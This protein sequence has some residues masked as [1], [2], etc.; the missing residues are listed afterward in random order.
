MAISAK[1]EADFTQFAAAVRTMEGHLAGFERTTT[2]TGTE[3]ST[4]TSTAKASSNTF[5]QLSQG[6]G[7]VDRTLGLL[8]IHIGPEIHALREMGE[9]AAAAQGGLSALA[10]GL[11]AVGAAFA[12]YQL[13]EHWD[14]IQ[15]S[16]RSALRTTDGWIATLVGEA[17]PA[18]EAAAAKLDLL[19]RASRYANT[20]ITDYGEA[21][22]IVVKHEEDLA[23][24]AKAAQDALEHQ[25]A[26][27]R[28]A[29]LEEFD[30][31]VEKSN[32]RVREERKKATDDA[33]AEA[34]RLAV[35]SDS[36]TGGDA[37]KKAQDYITVMSKMPSVAAMN[38][39][40]QREVE[41]AL[42]A[43]QEAMARQGRT[44]TELFGQITRWRQ[45]LLDL[46]PTE[47]E[48][49]IAMQAEA[50]AAA[51]LKTMEDAYT[52][53]GGTDLEG[54]KKGVSTGIGGE[55]SGP[56]GLAPF[57]GL[58]PSVFSAGGVNAPGASNVTVNMSGML[59]S[60]NPAAKEEL[61]GFVN[62]LVAEGLKR[63]RKVS[64]F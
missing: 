10:L 63:S 3:L 36:L 26:A 53:S 30:Q 29:F 24:S 20:T 13:Y 22:K 46:I 2:K 35:I 37:L 55:P 7:A 44:A 58:K 48:H 56:G 19:A 59:V 18:A 57:V 61:R 16:T 34:K 8:G 14:K 12:A 1:F 50:A 27:M 33:E 51:A 25:R 45:A 40:A 64:P 31:R 41:V 17:N 9:A 15:E 11:G 32:T 38:V 52:A 21:L 47:K 62:D 43:A 23:T 5:A 28:K 49:T 4:F 6:L 42:A 54:F 60:N 39:E